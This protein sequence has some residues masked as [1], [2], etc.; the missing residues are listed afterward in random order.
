MIHETL[1]SGGGITQAKG[2]DQELIVTL[3]SSKG[4]LGNVFLFHMY[5]VVSRMEILFGKVLSTTQ[6]IQKVIN[7]KNGKFVFDCD[8]VE[9]TEIKTHGPSAFFLEYHDYRRIIRVGIGMDKT[10]F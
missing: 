10:R 4:S 9:G 2:N 1:K 8:F 7:G 6:F 3:M 5:L